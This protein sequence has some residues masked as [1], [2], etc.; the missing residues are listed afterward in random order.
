MKVVYIAAPMWADTPEE[1][2][3]N[4]RRAVAWVVWAFRQGVAP[5]CSWLVMTAAIE[6][7]EESR[8]SGLAVDRAQAERCDEIWLVAGRVS[9]GMRDAADHCLPKGVMV[10]DLTHLGPWPPD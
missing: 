2:E 3:E 10:V 7:T 5:E 1:R 6:E 9:G 8:A 4:R